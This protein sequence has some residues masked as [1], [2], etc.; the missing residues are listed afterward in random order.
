MIHRDRYGNIES[1]SF[2]WTRDDVLDRAQGLGHDDFPDHLVEEV[3]C[4][5]HSK[6]NAEIGIN[7]TVLD[8]YIEM[9]VVNH[10]A[11]QEDLLKD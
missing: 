11:G 2:V 10:K 4:D 9:A 7:W 8:T 6:H 3:L 5:M 1:V